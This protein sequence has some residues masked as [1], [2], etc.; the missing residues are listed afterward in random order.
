M[1]PLELA[2][3]LHAALT[4]ADRTVV[5]GDGIHDT[6]TVSVDVGDPGKARPLDKARASALGLCP[7]K[8]AFEARGVKPTHE[9]Q[10]YHLFL[11][12]KLV[13]AYTAAALKNFLPL[14]LG[15]VTTEVE[16]EYEN[17]LGHVDILLNSPTNEATVIECKFSEKST[18]QDHWM[19]QAALYQL[20][21]NAKHAF[22][23]VTNRYNWTIYYLWHTYEFGEDI[24][25]AQRF[26]GEVLEDVNPYEDYDLNR[27]E[28]LEAINEQLRYLRP[29][30]TPLAIDRLFANYDGKYVKPAHWQCFTV[31]AQP[32]RYKTNRGTSG[33]AAG[34]VK[35][36]AGKVSC[37]F[38]GHCHPV[39]S[40]YQSEFEITIG[41]DDQPGLIYERDSDA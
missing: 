18:I 16:V 28:L 12:G 23:I 13:G 1:N 5:N 30:E 36:G 31:L 14:G 41:D 24:W 9:S 17:T 19:M 38:A 25:K 2:K 6:F 34:E 26:T 27:A 37:P 32:Y 40:I 35:P 8:A 11:M 33:Y 3:A 20:A 15:R 7:T 10:P 4:E 22:V 39:L 29:E 21:T